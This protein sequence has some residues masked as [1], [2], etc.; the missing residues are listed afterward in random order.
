MI[1]QC[2]LMDGYNAIFMMNKVSTEEVEI[3]ANGKEYKNEIM[4]NAKLSNFF[5]IYINFQM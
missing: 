5:F 1:Q 3:I 2:L 4:Y